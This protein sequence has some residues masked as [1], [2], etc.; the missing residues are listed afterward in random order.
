MTYSTSRQVTP[1]FEPTE[2]AAINIELLASPTNDFGSQASRPR[3]RLPT[4]RKSTRPLPSSTP[5]SRDASISTSATP[6]ASNPTLVTA[7]TASSSSNQQLVDNSTA[8]SSVER[9]ALER[10]FA[11]RR[12][13]N[14]ALL[15]HCQRFLPKYPHRV[16]YRLKPAER[17]DPWFEFY[18]LDMISA[19]TPDEPL[20]PP[21]T[22]VNE[23]NPTEEK[24]PPLEFAWTN[25]IIPGN[26]IFKS[27]EMPD[28][29][30]C[31][32]PCN[33]MSKTCT[34]AKAQLA[35]FAK[36]EYMPAEGG[37]AYSPAGLLKTN[38]YPIF[39]CTEGCGCDDKCSNRVSALSNVRRIM[40]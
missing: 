9:E 27:K 3:A 16:W 2:F 1:S 33:P 5:A 17:A 36:Y 15:E 23:V 28:G 30:D 24:C 11:E 31:D 18:Y 21:F 4:A 8:T 29:C 12:A 39:E 37:F 22:I 7:T 6:T 19:A 10:R 35:A 34:C 14:I 13:E 32:G 20:S 26:G 25:N 38:E 40:C